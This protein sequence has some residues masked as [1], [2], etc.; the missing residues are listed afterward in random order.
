MIDCSHTFIHLVGV[1]ILVSD[2]KYMP[3]WCD[4][5]WNR[6]CL[7]STDSK[8]QYLNISVAS[9]ENMVYICKE[10]RLCAVVLPQ[11]NRRLYF[12]LPWQYN[13]YSF[14]IH[15]IQKEI[16][17]LQLDTIALEQYFHIAYYLF[18]WFVFNVHGKQL[19]SRQDC[20]LYVWHMLTT[21]PGEA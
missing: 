2:P 15:D 19:M 12:S 7:Q 10:Q 17:R 20:Q 8:P 21:F 1:I 4:C 14:Y 18:V 11:T 5:Q 13:L 3:Y 9:W 6:L 16:S